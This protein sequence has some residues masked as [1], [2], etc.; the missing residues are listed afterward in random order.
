MTPELTGPVLWPRR[1]KSAWHFVLKSPQGVENSQRFMATRP[2]TPLRNWGL[3]RPWGKSMVNKPWSLFLGYVWG[4]ARLTSHESSWGNW[5]RTQ[6]RWCL[7]N[8]PLSG[9]EGLKKCEEVGEPKKNNS[10]LAILCDLFGMLKWPFQSL[11]DLQ[12]G[13]KKSH[14]E[15]PGVYIYIYTKNT[16][17]SW[18]CLTSKKPGRDHKCQNQNH[19]KCCQFFGRWVKQ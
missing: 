6:P 8:G 12:L 19:K 17:S 10:S 18:K 7:R 11:S 14:F 16:N 9:N 3:V 5:K 13:D 15:S 1:A 4:G 2:R